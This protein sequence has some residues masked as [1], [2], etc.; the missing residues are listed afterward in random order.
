[1]TRTR[2]LTLMATTL[3]VLLT[4]QSAFAMR[5]PYGTMPGPTPTAGPVAVPS[6]VGGFQP[7]RRY[8][9]GM[10]LYQYARSNSVNRVDPLGTY[11]HQHCCTQQ[12]LQQIQAAEQA[13]QNVAQNVQQVLQQKF[14]QQSFLKNYPVMDKQQPHKITI[15][16]ANW[17]NTLDSKLQKT[18]AGINNNSYGV[19]CESNCS[20]GTDAYV[21]PGFLTIGVDDDI[22]LCPG[23][24]NA[25]ASA[26]AR[27]L[28]HELTHYY[29]GTNDRGLGILPTQPNQSWSNFADDAHWMDDFV[30]TNPEDHIDRFLS[31]GVGSFP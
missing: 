9:D 14:D 19:E 24:F 29:A 26:Q 10:N 3:A 28:F 11:S 2:L 20:Q 12:Q 22:H 7:T 27:I 18:Q 1:M 5:D 30:N 4:S 25:G 23:F 17:Y 15:K 16:H 6:G 13:I 8:A 21:R 31:G